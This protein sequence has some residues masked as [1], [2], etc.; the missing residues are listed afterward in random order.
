MLLVGAVGASVV[1]FSSALGGAVVGR[2]DVAF[3]VGLTGCRVE[4]SGVF[5]LLALLCSGKGTGGGAVGLSNMLVSR[6]NFSSF[7]LVGCAF[8]V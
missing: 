6:L 4:G 1:G 3:D 8:V 5:R 2:N 7:S